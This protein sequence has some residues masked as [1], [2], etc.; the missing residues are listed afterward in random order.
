[1]RNILANAI[2]ATPPG[3][4]ISIHA[5]PSGNRKVEVSIHDTGPGIPAERQQEIFELFVTDKPAGQG[6]GL[7]LFIAA[8]IIREHNG[9]LLCESGEGDG[10]RFRLFLPIV[11]ASA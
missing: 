4:I 10:S 2:D 5:K 6:T 9:S 8:Q 11:E 1:M 7:G 3:G